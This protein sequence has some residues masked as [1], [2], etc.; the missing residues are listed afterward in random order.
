MGQRF[1]SSPKHSCKR[2][3]KRVAVTNLVALVIE[4]RVNQSAMLIE[5]Y[6]DPFLLVRPE[7]AVQDTVAAK[8]WGLS[9]SRDSRA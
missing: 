4:T 9:N 7:T 6:Y 8:M 1:H 3:K 5:N 2:G